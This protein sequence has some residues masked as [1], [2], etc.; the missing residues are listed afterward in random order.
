MRPTQLNN[1]VYYYNNIGLVYSNILF[2]KNNI[3]PLISI[4]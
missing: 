1:I 3:K 2:I 4:L